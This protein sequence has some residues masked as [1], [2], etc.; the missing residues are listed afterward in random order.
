MMATDPDLRRAGPDEHTNSPTSSP[1]SSLAIGRRVPP[2]K[3]TAILAPLTLFLIAGWFRAG[4]EKVIDP[5]W[6]TGVHLVEFLDSQR[7]AMLAFFVPFSDHVLEPLAPLVAW[8]V[9]WMQLAIAICLT[10]NRHVKRALWAGIVPDR[11]TPARHDRECRSR[12]ST[13]DAVTDRAAA[14]A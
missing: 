5:E 9:V 1:T 3:K 8:L 13:F 6:W 14:S 7:P 10:T 11:G 2:P 4:V 12:K